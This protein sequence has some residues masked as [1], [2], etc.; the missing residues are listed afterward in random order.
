MTEAF[1]HFHASR[2]SKTK[3]QHEATPFYL[4]VLAVASSALIPFMLCILDRQMNIA[5][6]NFPVSLACSGTH[7]DL[8]LRTPMQVVRTVF[9]I[10]NADSSNSAAT[11]L[12][13]PGQLSKTFAARSISGMLVISQVPAAFGR[14]GLFG[15]VLH[16]RLRTTNDNSQAGMSSYVI[17]SCRSS[18]GKTTHTVR[19]DMLTCCSFVV[20][21]PLQATAFWGIPFSKNKTASFSERFS[22]GKHMKSREIN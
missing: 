9:Q 14:C 7:F 1:H 11:Q 6:S 19:R 13:A 20:H 18:F 21:Y 5:A 3:W 12:E 8:R 16:V 4:P 17:G 22:S 2:R 10:R 15:S